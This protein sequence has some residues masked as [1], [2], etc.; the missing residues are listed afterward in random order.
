MS[1]P[2]LLRPAN[3]GRIQRKARALTFSP[4][5]SY[6]NS[7]NYTSKTRETPFRDLPTPLPSASRRLDLSSR[8]DGPLPEWYTFDCRSAYRMIL[9]DE[10]AV[11]EHRRSCAA[12]TGLG[13]RGL[14]LDV[15]EFLGATSTRSRTTVSATA[16]IVM[17]LTA[18]GTA[19]QS[20]TL[21]PGTLSLALPISRPTRLCA[22]AHRVRAAIPR[23]L[24]PKRKVPEMAGAASLP[25]R[26]MNGSRG[27]LNPCRKMCK[28]TE[29]IAGLRDARDRP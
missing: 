7:S 17:I 24:Y 28:W 15:G 4:G 26:A 20:L 11:A 27:I 3:T 23:W 8:M 16:G 1:L 6:L 9:A 12:S 21:S 5:S 29:R 19:R 18:R 14:F 2:C 25:T 22:A 13:C 10:S